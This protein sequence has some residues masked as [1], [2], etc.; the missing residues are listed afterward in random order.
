[1]EYLTT[2][3]MSKKWNISSRRIIPPCIEGRKLNAEFGKDFSVDTLENMRKFY[4]IYQNRISE[5]FYRNFAL[6]KS[7]KF[8]RIL[9]E[10]HSFQLSWSYYVKL[11]RV[12]N[13]MERQFYEL[14]SVKK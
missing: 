13:E 11:M 2:V 5:K 12:E 9:E 3:K 8:S 1:M 7:D 6:E 4:V 10:E 14:E